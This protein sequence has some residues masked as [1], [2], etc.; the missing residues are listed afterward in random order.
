[1]QIFPESASMRS[2]G[3]NE[4]GKPAFHGEGSPGDRAGAPEADAAGR[5]AG[6]FAGQK[7][8]GRE[9]EERRI[10]SLKDGELSQVKKEIDRAITERRSSRERKSPEKNS[11][12]S[13]EEKPE[14]SLAAQAEQKSVLPVKEGDS[15]TVGEQRVLLTSRSFR[16]RAGQSTG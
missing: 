6:Q 8:S 14:N 15:Y 13:P 16:R 4:K 12:M 2:R 1:M 9:A 5:F 7:S 3:A 11:T 10:A